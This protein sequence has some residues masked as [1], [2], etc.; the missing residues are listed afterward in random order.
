MVAVVVFGVNEA[1]VAHEVDGLSLV[2]DARSPAVNWWSLPF[3][4][5]VMLFDE[6]V[7]EV[8]FLQELGHLFEGHGVESFSENFGF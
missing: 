1:D 2:V 4:N 5:L 8:A 3:G 6:L 7:L